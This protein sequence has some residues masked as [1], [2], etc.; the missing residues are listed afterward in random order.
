[1]EQRRRRRNRV[2]A[3]TVGKNLARLRRQSGLSQEEL[4]F[5]ADFHRTDI[6]KLERGEAAPGSETLFKISESLGV[7]ASELFEGLSWNPPQTSRGE[8]AAHQT[9]GGC[10]D[11]KAQ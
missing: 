7:S 9:E 2:F 3:E 4:G 6:S 8:V 5:R 10:A 11:G 1:M